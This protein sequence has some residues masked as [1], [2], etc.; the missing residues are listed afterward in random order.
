MIKTIM[1]HLRK[2]SEF[3]VY[4]ARRYQNDGASGIAASLSYTSLLSL[5]PLMAI[6]LAMLAA[7]PVFGDMRTELQNWVF[8]NFVPSVGRTV[9][10]QVG[11]FISNAGRLSAAG[12]VGL[13][14]SAILLLV[15][16]ETSFNTVFRV[17]RPR[18]ALSRV[19]VYWTVMTLGPLLLGAALSLQSTLSTLSPWQMSSTILSTLA[20]PL[21]ILLTMAAFTIL[22]ATI[23]NRQVRP[24]DAL[25]GGI[26]AGLLFAALHYGFALYIIHTDS[27]TTVYGAVAV[28]PIVLFW[29]FL[30]WVVVLIG[31]E[32]TA[33][34][35]EWRSGQGNGGGNGHPSAQRKLTLALDMLAVLLTASRSNPGSVT[36]AAL[37]AAS[38]APEGQFSLV[39]HRLTAASLVAITA[40]HHILLARD[41]SL[42]TLAELVKDLDLTPALDSD[43]ATNTPW[44]PRVEA[45]LSAAHIQ[46]GDV[47]NV[48]LAEVLGQ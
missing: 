35:P 13:A 30:S 29:G 31:A 16:I 42:V 27:Y 9:E 8:H 28:V 37:L 1:T 20:M 32:I 2:A 11:N 46:S 7:F 41:M 22:F 6:A 12:I 19:L 23:P 47:L 5:V 43:F 21:P 39:L 18:S 3:I 45:L 36:R 4:V 48:S 15:S 44:R 10:E 40:N 25:V 14:V 33:A 38:T 17:T 26:T 24:H 34:L